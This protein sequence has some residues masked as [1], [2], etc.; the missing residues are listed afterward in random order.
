MRYWGCSR[1]SCVS[2]FQLTQF[3]WDWAHDFER[4]F[5]SDFW[6]SFVCACNIFFYTDPTIR[7]LR[8]QKNYIICL[9]VRK[10]V[11]EFQKRRN[12]SHQNM[13]IQVMSDDDEEEVRRTVGTHQHSQPFFLCLFR[14]HTEPFYIKDFLFSS[15]ALRV[16]SEV[17]RWSNRATNKT[18]PKIP[19]QITIMSTQ[20]TQFK[21]N[22][23]LFVC[24]EAL[25][26]TSTT[27]RIVTIVMMSVSR[28]RV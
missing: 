3:T 21:K 7:C 1:P 17:L 11:S 15:L 26:V 23:F 14:L 24:C 5:L 28:V 16:F 4:V 10:R 8:K 25:N 27:M 9:R 19:Q 2:H 18:S 22:I 6:N 12:D 13:R 20:F